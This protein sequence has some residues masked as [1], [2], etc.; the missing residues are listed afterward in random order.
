MYKNYIFDFYGTLVDIHTDEKKPALWE[1]MADLYRV[2]G[3]DYTPEELKHA[4][5]RQC[6]KAEDRLRQK[7]GIKNVEIDLAEVFASLLKEAPEIHPTSY[8][9]QDWNEWTRAIANTFRILSRERFHTYPYTIQVLKKL[10][11]R[12]C[13]LYI[14]S[15][16]QE[17]FTMA[18]IEESGVFP[19]MDK[20]Y[21][22]STYQIKKP[23]PAFLADLLKKEKLK[24]EDSILIGNDCYSDIASAV[25]NQISSV[26]L[27][28]GKHTERQRKKMIKDVCSEKC[29]TPYVIEDGDIRKILKIK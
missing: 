6:Q 28:T 14:L 21:L 10:K 4:Y 24:R 25:Q 9:I 15:N 26:F 5:L 19:Y 1:K 27:D 13:H 18:E 22:S 8:T 11:E 16:A 7:K 17:S 23:E 20:I 12:D 2:Y 29:C 3:A